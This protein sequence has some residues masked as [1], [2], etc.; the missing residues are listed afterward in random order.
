MSTIGLTV[1]PLAAQASL[2]FV[3]EL[4]FHRRRGLPR[5][6]RIG[7]PMDTL[8]VLM[9]YA[10][11]VLFEPTG[12][13]LTWYVVVACISCLLITKDEFLHASLCT[14]CEHWIHAMLFVLHPIV[15]ASVAAL[16]IF[17][18]RLA[19][20]F[21]A[22]MTIAFWVYQIIYWGVLNP[23]SEAKGGAR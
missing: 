20:L 21:Q 4:V 6:E 3:D 19:I 18:L 13:A 11:A 8:S 15:L 23:P 5:W 16:W 10:I 9:C 14:A 17:H 7:H 1:I 22:S 2:M 12:R